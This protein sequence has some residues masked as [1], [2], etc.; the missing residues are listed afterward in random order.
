MRQAPAA[1]AARRVL[2]VDDSTDA[3]DSL[4]MLLQMTGHETHMAHDGLD[5]IEAVDK[6]RPEVV[7]LDIGLPSLNGYEVCR[8]VRQRPWG[9]NITLVALTGWEQEKDRSKSRE[10]GFDGHLVKPV[11]FPSL[12][13]AIVRVAAQSEKK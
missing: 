7:L 13:Q 8:H 11:E 5:A 2:V 3:A 4:A 1:G 6:H 12:H 9:K 10:A